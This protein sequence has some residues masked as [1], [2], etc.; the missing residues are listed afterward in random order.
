MNNYPDWYPN[1]MLN[2]EEDDFIVDDDGNVVLPEDVEP[3]Y[4][5]PEEQVYE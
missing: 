4:E 1:H 5:E 2:D 3:L